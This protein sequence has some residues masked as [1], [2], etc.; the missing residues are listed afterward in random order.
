HVVKKVWQPKLDIQP[1]FRKVD[2]PFTNGVVKVIQANSI[3]LTPGTVT[4]RVDDDKLLVHS[5]TEET[6]AG[7]DSPEMQQKLE[8]LEKDL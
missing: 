7:L 3:T 2:S 5:L 8:A 6:L 1:Q 4:I